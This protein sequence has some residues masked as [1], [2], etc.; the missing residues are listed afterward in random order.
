MHRQ[1]GTKYNAL[2]SYGFVAPAVLFLIAMNVFPLFYSIVLSFSNADLVGGDWQ[3]IGTRNYE[4]IFKSSRYS[5]ALRTTA[6]FVFTAVTIEIALGFAL[7][8]CIKDK[9][10]FKVLVLTL[11]L[12]PMMLPQS[13][14]GLFWKLILNGNYGILNQVISNL[15]FSEPQWITDPGLKFFSIVLI[16]VWMWTPFMMLI[17][18]AALNAIPSHLYEAAAIDRAS[19]WRVFR[20]ITLPMCGPLLG[21]AVLLRATDALK[22]FDIVMTITGPN[23]RV[24]QTLSAL[25]YQVVFRDGKVGQGAA[26]S[27]VVLVVVIALA[28]LFIRYLDQVRKNGESG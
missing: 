9:F 5:Q 10:R 23:D 28:S 19:S 2:Q 3:W 4:F 27:Y 25:L 15:G 16:D 1:N 17:S 7:A 14:M 11:L 18:M 13:V 6:L 8:F 21:L 26:Y 20:R 24:T 12:V 22:Q